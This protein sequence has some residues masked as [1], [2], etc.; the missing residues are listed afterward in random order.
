MLRILVISTQIPRDIV[1]EVNV[2]QPSVAKNA[3]DVSTG[4]LIRV[5]ELI[6][7]NKRC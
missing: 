6:V 2:L 7:I 1:A 5:D 3:A 4:A